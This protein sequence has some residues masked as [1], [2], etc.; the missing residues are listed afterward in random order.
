MNYFNNGKKFKFFW[1]GVR[2]LLVTASPQGFL[3]Q[4]E[5]DQD[6]RSGYPG[7]IRI[8]LMDNFIL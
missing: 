6:I 8:F 1:E 5:Q 3:L 7:L 4:S 2:P